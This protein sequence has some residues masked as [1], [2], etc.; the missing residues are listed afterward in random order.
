MNIFTRAY[1]GQSH[2]L[3]WLLESTEVDLRILDVVLSKIWDEKAICWKNF[4]NYFMTRQLLMKRTR[5][6]KYWKF[7]E[8]MFTFSAT[9]ILSQLNHSSKIK[10]KVL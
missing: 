1:F 9:K 5:L 4:F 7:F 3:A 10:K 6:L 2:R 8:N